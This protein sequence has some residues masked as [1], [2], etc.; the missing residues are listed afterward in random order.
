MNKVQHSDTN[1]R[2]IFQYTLVFIG[3]PSRGDDG[4]GPALFHE[5]EPWLNQQRLGQTEDKQIPSNDIQLIECFQLEPELC[6]DIENS[7]VVIIIDASTTK[8]PTPWVETLSDSNAP[9]SIWTHAISPS[10][11]LTLFKKIHQ[12]SPP[13]TY[14][15]HIPGKKFG[16]GAPLSPSVEKHQTYCLCLLQ[17]ICLATSPKNLKEIFFDITTS[18][19]KGNGLRF[20]NEGFKHA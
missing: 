16:L 14:L 12:K 10:S 20:E 11:L 15:L 19:S 1:R 8:A 18:T 3:N 13:R 9:T 2:E 7:D 4:I 6:C 5:I 17:K